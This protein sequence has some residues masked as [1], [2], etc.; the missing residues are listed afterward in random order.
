MVT[1]DQD[2]DADADPEK[3]MLMF[4]PEKTWPASNQV[5]TDDHDADA[6]PHWLPP[7]FL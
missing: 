5:V 3:L 6:G 4:M 2:A 1:D 7:A